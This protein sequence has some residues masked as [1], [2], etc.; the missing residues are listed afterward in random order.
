VTA[1]S[2]SLS[3]THFYSITFSKP[4]R[5]SHPDPLRV[6]SAPHDSPSHAIGSKRS[7]VETNGSSSGIQPQFQPVI[8]H[9]PSTQ[10][11]SRGCVARAA[12]DRKDATFQHSSRQRTDPQQWTPYRYPIPPTTPH[13]NYYPLPP[14][15][16]PPR[17]QPSIMNLFR[18]L[19]KS[20]RWPHLSRKNVHIK[21]IKTIYPPPLRGDPRL[22]P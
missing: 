13:P 1:K 11:D 22:P 3:L 8:G 21:V 18:A 16:N 7:S 19:L 2:N 10:V 5:L 12:A 6:V 14:Q 9:D 20:S 4:N 15:E 17:K